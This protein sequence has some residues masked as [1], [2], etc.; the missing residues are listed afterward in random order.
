LVIILNC[1]LINLSI[2][3]H[4]L[5]VAAASVTSYNTPGVLHS[6]AKFRT[7]LANN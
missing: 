2:F 1:Q 6:A 3:F 4:H 5:N 7:K